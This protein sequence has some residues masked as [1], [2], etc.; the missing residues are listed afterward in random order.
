MTTAGSA[1]DSPGL[2]VL[3]WRALGAPAVGLSSMTTAFGVRSALGLV[4]PASC[5]GARTGCH[6]LPPSGS[7][8]SALDVSGTVP[9]LSRPFQRF[10]RP[11]G[12]APPDMP[13]GT[14]PYRP[15]GPP[16]IVLPLRED[17]AAGLHGPAALGTGRGVGHAAH[18]NGATSSSRSNSGCSLLLGCCAGHLR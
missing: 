17:E 8:M 6:V 3:A 16:V 15:A 12:P 10:V 2:P 4:G 11:V 9:V 1:G 14:P 13:T 7:L 5:T 18:S